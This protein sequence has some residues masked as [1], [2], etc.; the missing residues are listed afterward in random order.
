M[1]GGGDDPL[2]G[3][4][5]HLGMHMAIIHGPAD[6]LIEVVIDG[7]S[8]WTGNCTGGSI[9]INKPNL[10]GGYEKEGGVIGSVDIEMGGPTQGR[11]AY[12]QSQLGSDVSAFRRIVCG[13]LK[14]PY[15]GMSSYLKKWAWRF[16]RIHTRSDNTVQ[17]YDAKA[18]IGENMNPAHII[19][20]CKTDKTWGEGYKAVDIDD[21]SFIAAADTLYNEGMGMSI[22]WGTGI[23]IGKFIDEIKRHINASTYTSRTTGKYVIKLIRDDYDIATLPVLGKSEILKVSNFVRPT[24]ADL[25]SEVTVVARNPKNNGDAPV[26][27]RNIALAN[28]QGNPVGTK[29]KFKGFCDAT[30]AARVAARELKGRSTPLV[31]TTL[32]VT[33]AAGWELNNGDP[34]IWNWE[35]Y[36]ISSMVMRVTE[37]EFG[38]LE[39]NTIKI[40]CVED[41]FGTNDLE[42]T[43]PPPSGWQDITAD[44]VAIDHR[45]LREMPYWD[46]AR[47]IGDDDAQALDATAGYFGITGVQPIGAVINAIMYVD[48]DGAGS[49]EDYEKPSGV[50]PVNLCPSATITAALTPGTETF[51]FENAE[52]MEMVQDGTYLI[53]NDEIMIIESHTDSSLTVERGASDTVPKAHASG[54]RFFCAQKYFQTDKVQYFDAET[55]RVKLCSKTSTDELPLISAPYDELTFDAR[56]IR[57]YP[58]GNVKINTAYFPAA[59]TGDVV[60]TWAGRNRLTQTA[61]LVG[62]KEGSI[63]PEA[64]TTY[65]CQLINADTSALIAESTGLTAETVTFTAAQVGTAT[66]LKVKLWSL[67]DTYASWQAFEHVFTY[68]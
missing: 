61:A 43:V 35:P 44:A 38:T 4:M 18:A 13:V 50:L 33:F 3:Y 11:N 15:L 55:I 17:W 26:T 22:L 63:T 20:E 49:A 2:I 1:G 39:D 41:V 23:R 47:K 65:T 37:L 8:A 9:S 21:A 28:M 53:L 29:L 64:G 24:P 30:N 51:S 57:P 48:A 12:L 56:Q 6:K 36:G 58:P 60:V 66:D 52:D 14:K 42:Y 45:I 16:Q 19:R 5:Y 27:A 7:K 54:S 62:F 25:I 68:S 46:V 10:F 31:K 32:Q 59:A 40:D 67:R 34:F